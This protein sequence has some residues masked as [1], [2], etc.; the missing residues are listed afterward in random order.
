MNRQHAELAITEVQAHM[1]AQPDAVLIDVRTHEEFL[2]GHLPGARNIPVDRV[3]A[4]IPADIPKRSTPLIVYCRT[5]SRSA[6]VVRL[7]RRLGYDHVAD[8][9]GLIDYTGTLDYGSDHV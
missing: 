2:S 8:A 4:Q 3:L 7:L 1:E 9:G 5:G 6:F